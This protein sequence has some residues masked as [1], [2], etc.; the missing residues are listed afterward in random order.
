MAAVHGKPHSIARRFSR[1]A[2][3]NLFVSGCPAEEQPVRRDVLNRRGCSRKLGAAQ[4]LPLV[5]TAIL[6][7]DSK[8]RR[9]EATDQPAR[10]WL[11]ESQP[12]LVLGINQA[13]CRDFFRCVLTTD[14]PSWTNAGRG[15]SGCRP[16]VSGED[17]EEASGGGARQS[18]EMSVEVGLQEVVSDDLFQPWS[19]RCAPADGSPRATGCCAEPRPGYGGS[20]MP[21]LGLTCH[22]S[23]PHTVQ[24]RDWMLLATLG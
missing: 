4:L 7:S 8:L 21:L 12:S 3:M 9:P 13:V 5:A 20:H 19:A 24:S 17:V 15:H 10:R 2:P 22:G 11:S 6:G 23:A 1:L 18:S 16:Q 14:R